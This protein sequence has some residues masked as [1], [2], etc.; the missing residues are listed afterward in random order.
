MVTSTANE[1]SRARIFFTSASRCRQSW[2][3]TPSTM[4]NLIFGDGPAAADFGAGKSRPAN[5]SQCISRTKCGFMGNSLPVS[6]SATT[7]IRR[8]G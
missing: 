5:K 2:L 7:K 6:D 3:L 8:H 1:P 4:S